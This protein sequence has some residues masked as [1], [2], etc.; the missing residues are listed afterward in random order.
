M[1]TAQPFPPN[2]AKRGCHSR[3]QNRWLTKR[4][5]VKYDRRSELKCSRFIHSTVPPSV[6]TNGTLKHILVC[7]CID[8]HV[9]LETRSIFQVW[10]SRIQNDFT[11]SRCECRPTSRRTNKRGILQDSGYFQETKNQTVRFH[12]TRASCCFDS[13]T[14]ASQKTPKNSVFSPNSWNFISP[15]RSSRGKIK[16]NQLYFLVFQRFSCQRILRSSLPAER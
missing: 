7:L 9:P 13:P 3:E 2:Q 12:R 14:H 8:L 4:P 6:R 1:R 15:G 16:L 5:D 11:R 10:T